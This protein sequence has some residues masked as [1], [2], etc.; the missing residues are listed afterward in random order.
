[1]IHVTHDQEEALFLADQ[2]AV[3]EH[4]RLRQVGKPLDVYERPAN[5][6]VAGFVGQPPMNLLQMEN[7]GLIGIRPQHVMLAAVGAGH[8]TG[9]LESL[10][11][12]GE[13]WLAQVQVKGLDTWIRCLLPAKPGCEVGQPVSVHWN[14][15]RL[16]RFDAITGERLPG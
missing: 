15:D 10:Q 6:F 2:L 4:G 8:L 1:M 14:Q 13:T 9:V 11:P 5:A 16:H 3:M 12:V 7:D